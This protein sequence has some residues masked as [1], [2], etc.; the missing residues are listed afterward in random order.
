ML[1]KISQLNL[2]YLTKSCRHTLSPNE[3]DLVLNLFFCHILRQ[4]RSTA[5]TL[6]NE[7]VDIINSDKSRI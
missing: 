5:R 1:T 7:V 3:K 6:R 2:S 4:W